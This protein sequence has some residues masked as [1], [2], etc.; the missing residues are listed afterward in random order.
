MSA[1]GPSTQEHAFE[2]LESLE[3]YNR[4]I[5]D[6]LRPHAGCRVL[7]VGAG[8]GN[9]TR[10]FQTCDEVLAVDIDPGFANRF[11]TRFGGNPRVKV[12]V[13]DVAAPED[14]LGNRLFDTILCVNV[15][16]HIAEDEMTLKR[17]RHHLIPGGR[18]LLLVPAHQALYGGVDE[19]AGH[20]RR[21]DRRGLAT[22]LVAAG[23]TVE[24]I[25][26]FNMLGALGWWVNVR[27]LRRRYLPDGQS[28]LLN[29][30]VPLLRL[31]DRISPPFG[32]SLIAIATR[33]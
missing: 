21:Y 2:V 16:E 25:R 31:E 15:L 11:A 30:L 6:H 32:L 33:R 18:L 20:V 7:E 27:V 1:S 29:H 14:P 9:L 28:R 3:R 17:F 19:S 8:T 23:F 10:F 12:E 22:K 13:M 5:V 24:R 4:W 26:Y